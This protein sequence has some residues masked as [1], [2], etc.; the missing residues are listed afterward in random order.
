MANNTIR[1][2]VRDGTLYM[3]RLDGGVVFEQN[4]ACSLLDQYPLVEQL[5]GHVQCDSV[6]VYIALD[7]YGRLVPSGAERRLV[8]RHLTLPEMRQYCANHSLQVPLHL[9]GADDVFSVPAP[10]DRNVRRRFI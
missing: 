5:S 4:D 7:E 8:L 6:P 1:A 9:R 10:Y 3:I 2:Q